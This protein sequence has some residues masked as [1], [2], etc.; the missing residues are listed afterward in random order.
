[1]HAGGSET[2]MEIDSIARSI[3][4]VVLIP[5]FCGLP[6]LTGW[7]LFAVLELSVPTQNNSAFAAHQSAPITNL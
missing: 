4:G 2:G 3:K 7:I 5:I 6:T 1:M